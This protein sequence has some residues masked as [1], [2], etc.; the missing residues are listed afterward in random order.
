VPP[1]L[2]RSV[3]VLL[4][5][6]PANRFPNAAALVTALDT[7]EAPELRPEPSLSPQFSSQ[8]QSYGSGQMSSAK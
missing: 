6:E 2:A 4:E 5:K 3:M 1:D 7:R 8:R